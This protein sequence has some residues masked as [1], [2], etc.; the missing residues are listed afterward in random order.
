MTFLTWRE[1][2]Y[3]IQ[4]PQPYHGMLIIAVLL[5]GQL[6]ACPWLCSA[7][8]CVPTCVLDPVC[9]CALRY[10]KHGSCSA[11]LLPGASQLI[12]NPQCCTWSMI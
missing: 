7:C 10:A 5:A 9:F 12:W 6:K 3:I 1:E 4:L 8:A 2:L 11:L